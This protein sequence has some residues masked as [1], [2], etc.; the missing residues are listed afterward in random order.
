MGG[1]GTGG[2]ERKTKKRG[3]N[4]IRYKQIAETED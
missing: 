3:G 4:N 2:G 1:R